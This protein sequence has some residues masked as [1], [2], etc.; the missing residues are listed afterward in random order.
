MLIFR[1][2]AL[3]REMHGVALFIAHV[4][5]LVFEIPI[6]I[7]G[8]TRTGILKRSW[9]AK[10]RRYVFLLAFLVGAIITPTPDPFNQTI[11]AV[12]IYLLFE[13]GLL[14]ARFGG[15]RKAR[16]PGA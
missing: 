12:P 9:L 11:V 14:L 8:L 1:I 15:G 2:E 16:R 5:Q 4:E 10:Q 7:F 3:L 13:L 6:I